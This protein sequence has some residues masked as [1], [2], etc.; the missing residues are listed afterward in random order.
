MID[1]ITNLWESIKLLKKYEKPISFYNK[2]S[3]IWVSRRIIKPVC[4]MSNELSVN[5]TNL[6]SN[7]IK[8]TIPLIFNN[9]QRAGISLIKIKINGIEIYDYDLKYEELRAMSSRY[10]DPW[11]YSVLRFTINLKERDNLQISVPFGVNL[12]SYDQVDP[13]FERGDYIEKTFIQVESEGREDE[14]I[15]L[16]SILTQQKDIDNTLIFSTATFSILGLMILYTSLIIWV[17]KSDIETI[18]N[19]KNSY[20]I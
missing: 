2:K 3:S 14:V 5:I 11:P 8:I 4:S 9:F 20:L 16:E 1:Q 10:S 13:E 12:K 7:E 19:L 18:E 17:F 6:L 15:E